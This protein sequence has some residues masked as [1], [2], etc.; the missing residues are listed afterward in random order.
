MYIIIVYSNNKWIAGQIFEH[1]IH[2]E[3][4]DENGE[5]KYDYKPS[6]VDEYLRILAREGNIVISVMYC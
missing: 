6:D 2:H 3:Y 4:K 5:R 1:Y